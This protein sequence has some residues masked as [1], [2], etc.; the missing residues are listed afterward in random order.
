MVKHLSFLLLIILVMV[1]ANSEA[2]GIFTMA[3]S[4]RFDW[5]PTE[6]AHRRYPM[7]L[8]SGNLTL[9]D[10]SSL[11]VPAKAVIDNGWGE[12]GSAHIVGKTMK[13]LPVKLTASWFSFTEDKFYFGEFL[14]PYESILSFFKSI[15]SNS[16]DTDIESNWIVVGFGPDGAVSVWASAIGIQVEIGNYKASEVVRDW[17]SVLDNDQVSRADFIDQVLHISLKPQE[18]RA[19]KEH[20]VPPGISDYYSKQYWWKLS[21]SGQT[22]R[23]LWLKTLNG[24]EEFFDFVKT[25]NVRTSRGL[26]QSMEILWEDNSG[27]KYGADVRFDEAEVN[28]AFKKLSA[29]KTDHPMQLKME[30]TDNPYVIHTSLDDGTYVILLNKTAVKPYTRR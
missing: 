12:L 22:K 4:E 20:G 28:A 5:L 17:K 18:L 27:A 23:K 16:S 11:Y 25:A 7:T 21:V 13:A 14:L 24:E 3:T 8:I 26:P 9:K 15:R 30:I 29:G 19:F 2:K 1:P 10:G 6:C